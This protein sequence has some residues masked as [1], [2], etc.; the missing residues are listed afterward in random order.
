MDR[1]PWY[2]DPGEV[3]DF[4]RNQAVNLLPHNLRSRLPPNNFFF[5]A[6]QSE[7]VTGDCL[8]TAIDVPALRD[9]FGLRSAMERNAVWKCI[10]KLRGGSLG[11]STQHNFQAH[12]AQ[13][14]K[15]LPPAIL[16]ETPLQH[17]SEPVAASAEAESENRIGEH[18]RSGEF[19]VQDA[20][21]RKRR[22]LNLSKPEPET[23]ES[24]PAI[25]PRDHLP[26]AALS[27]DELFYGQTGFGEEI[28][29]LP[30]SGI[31]TLL[32]ADREDKLDD[33]DFQFYHHDKTV[34]EIEFAYNHMRHFLNNP[35][36]VNLQRQGRAALALL[37]YRQSQSARS[38]TVIQYKGTAEDEPVAFRE[39]A[40]Y[41]NSGAPEKHVEGGGEWDF[42]MD[43]YAA[44][45]DPI[46]PEYGESETALSQSKLETSDVDSASMAEESIAPDNLTPEQASQLI[47]KMMTQYRDAW[48]ELEHVQSL[49]EK[50]AYTIWKKT[51][52]SRTFRAH[53][54]EGAEAQIERLRN[55]LQTQK[56]WLLGSEWSSE[57]SLE[58][59]CG[60]LQAT[61]ED[62]EEHRWKIDV[63]GRRQEP[64][65]A[66]RKKTGHAR[67]QSHQANTTN[68]G[69]ASRLIIPRRDRFSVS[70]PPAG[71]E[72]DVPGSM[73]SDT[74]R[75]H[76]Y[77]Y[78]AD[79][80]EFH[81]PAASPE[82]DAESLYAATGA[83]QDA[84]PEEP[85]ASSPFVV[86]DN[87]MS[88]SM[89]LPE[90]GEEELQ[91]DTDVAKD[92]SR[93]NGVE[94]GPRSGVDSDE[95]P[96]PANWKSSQSVKR[97]IAASTPSKNRIMSIDLTADSPSSEAPTPKTKK[98]SN[99]TPSDYF[100]G[101][102]SHSTAQE[103]DQWQFSDL[104]KKGDRRRI[105]IKILR[106]AGQDKRE[107]LHACYMSLQKM[108]FVHGLS[109]TLQALRA[110][111]ADSLEDD[112]GDPLRLAA[113]I[114]LRW[115]MPELLTTATPADIPWDSVL[116]NIQIQV[117][118]KQLW[119]D[120]QKRNTPRF[121][122]LNRSSIAA[123]SSSANPHVLSSDNEKSSSPRT[124]AKKKKQKQEV[125]RSQVGHDVRAKA[126]ER[127]RK[128]ALAESQTGNSSQLA[129]MIEN[130]PSNSG[131]D[132]NPTRSDEA[133]PIYI[134]NKIAEKMKPHQIT[135]A[136]FLWLEVVT[137][138][139]ES[140][141]HG[142]VLAHT[143]GLG[144][145]MQTVAFLAAVNEAAQSKKP[146][147]RH[148]L[149]KR[150]RLKG[151]R[152]VRSVRSLVLCPPGLIPNW[153]REIESW[154]GK[155]LGHIFCLDSTV[156][157]AGRLPFLCDWMRLGGV[158][159]L[160]YDMFRSLVSQDSGKGKKRA[161]LPDDE[162][163][164]FDNILLRGPDIVIADEAHNL[165]NQSAAVSLA[166]SRCDTGHRIALTGTP[167]SNDVQEVYS[168]VS[169]ICPGYLGEPIEFRDYFAGPIKEG[170]YADS[171][172]S[173][174]RKSII[175]LKGL[176]E[177]IK[178]KVNRANIEALRGSIPPKV[179]FVIFVSLQPAQLEL[180][181]RYVRAVK[182]LV[183]QSESDG[184]SKKTQAVFLT[185]LA[186]LTLL[187]NHPYCFKLKM[188]EP[189]KIKKPKALQEREGEGDDADTDTGDQSTA[190]GS[191][192]PSNP[193]ITTTEQRLDEAAARMED[194]HVSAMG[195]T[196]ET[197]M[198]ILGGD[199]S[200]IG[201]DPS[202]SSK[203]LIFMSL[204]KSSL[205]A[206]DKAIVFSQRLQ[207]L[208]YLGQLFKRE[209]IAHG[210]IDGRD[211]S[212]R[213]ELLEEFE[214]GNFDVMLVSTRAG[215]VG[216]N[217]QCANRVFI[218]DSGFNPTYEEQAI[219]R[220]YRL[221]Q[222]QHV[223]VYRFVASGTFETNI[224]NKQ[225][226]K[227][228]LAQ[229]VVDKKNPRRNAERSSRDYLYEPK[230]VTQKDITEHIDKD[231]EVLGK[232]L[233]QH[234]TG[235][236][237]FDTMIRDVKTM[238]T[239]TEEIL[240][241][242]LDAEEQKLLA[243]EQAAREQRVKSKQAAAMAAPSSTM[244]YVPPPPRAPGLMPPPAS[245]YAAPSNRPQAHPLG[246]LPTSS[247]RM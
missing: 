184:P 186:V 232:L 204:L 107:Q 236:G 71:Q 169:W 94:S 66:A 33:N 11:Y 84:D 91:H 113:G 48:N 44:E 200:E 149:P 144:K 156:K 125:V 3:E 185:M 198:Q 129:A 214:D 92:R 136:R 72:A 247:R 194:D 120:L 93:G 187:T 21:G 34:G 85:Q 167:M 227:T 118:T 180:Y 170:L 193:D 54:I 73:E 216:I 207:V 148:Q 9:E 60:I 109:A 235:T 226:L 201:L 12:Q 182:A 175:R 19:Q 153:K 127:N 4:F 140:G 221:G 47:D 197:V 35:E 165:K 74:P 134:I 145:T 220:A 56:T 141:G 100:Q 15:S 215:G 172:R 65:H 16:P 146:S 123:G 190:S 121:R 128:L 7:G 143:M 213:M 13:T 181:R 79:D 173:E 61:V 29:E 157:Q 166:A 53:L 77:V 191:R 240:D 245:T 97:E 55:R 158:L 63:W 5:E 42:L 160:G 147:V 208:D 229:R 46:L 101:D 218:F 22:K 1:D 239:L 57:A 135:G 51:K 222:K 40:A 164:E 224:Y 133:S 217:M 59:M 212:T 223:Y 137:S 237:K 24:P 138:D 50:K 161:P 124:P 36:E 242:P 75:I 30:A 87:V 192:T 241:E 106:D 80:E 111:G 199:G 89:D 88:D 96:S 203:V 99:F 225:L 154:A 23:R 246:G 244:P 196:P 43:K 104:V 228:S 117:F 168:L 178:D 81:T 243:Q 20:Q 205:D 25:R 78:E 209:K 68:E 176:H 67:T 195:L 132:I 90:V 116:N 6:L 151:S 231:P 202:L 183:A 150:L 206:G 98:A 17:P 211:R 49:E 159:I 219:G 155:K 122:S 76:E 52:Q 70:P 2:W 28:G 62:I 32:E 64:W 41:L 139:N 37:P 103:A 27:I 38:A 31:I 130:D 234:G 163:A 69:A 18:T 162:V 131:I 26:K 45:D 238:E 142:C 174:Q 188:Q 210:R 189:P 14:P 110:E 115:H 10:C 126:A 95:L 105:L 152:D 83:I 102:P 39:N 119:D 230:E 112:R 108:K 177:D 58:K 8:L 171:T 179:E 114:F 82:P 233:K 86:S